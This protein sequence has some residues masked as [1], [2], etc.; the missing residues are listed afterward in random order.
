MIFTELMIRS[1]GPSIGHNEEWIELRNLTDQTLSLD[2][3]LLINED[4][5]GLAEHLITPV[6]SVTVS[7]GDYVVLSRSSA[8]DSLE[9]G[10]PSAY[11]YGNNI[12]FNNSDAETLSLHCGPTDN[13]VLVDSVTFDGGD[14]QFL[15]GLPRQL[16]SDSESATSND[17]PT[18]WCVGGNP[19]EFPWSCTVGDETNYGSPG[20]PS[21]CP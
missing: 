16:R 12:N 8:E 7:P 18:S 4:L 1:A 5:S 20:S 15:A 13:L 6:F 3:C 17:D 11:A 19:E 2:G 21:I 14:E 9:C 10:L